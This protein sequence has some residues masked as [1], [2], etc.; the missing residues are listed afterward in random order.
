MTRSRLFVNDVEEPNVILSLKDLINLL[1]ENMVCRDCQRVHTMEIC[2]ET[3]GIATK[4]SLACKNPICCKCDQ[5]SIIEP[6]TV[7][8]DELIDKNCNPYDLTAFKL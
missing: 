1:L 8:L 2:A 7:K 4:L 5:W 6:S 3:M